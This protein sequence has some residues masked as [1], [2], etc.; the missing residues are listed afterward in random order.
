VALSDVDRQPVI[1]T[2][3][4]P[5]YPPIARR[6]RASGTVILSVLVTET[7]TVGDI[8]VIR[9]AGGATGLTQAAENAV[10]QWTFAPAMK[11]GVPVKTWFTVPIPFVL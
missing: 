8:R 10:R 7:G 1:A 2:V 3:V 6:V 11:S 4:K 5:E 9:E